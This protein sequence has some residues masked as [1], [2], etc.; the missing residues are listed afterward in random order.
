MAIANQKDT[1]RTYVLFNPQLE[2]TK[3]ETPTTTLFPETCLWS[4]WEPAKN[5]MFDAHPKVYLVQTNRFSP[6]AAHSA[7]SRHFDRWTILETLFYPLFLG[8]C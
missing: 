8:S 5:R 1:V 6:L 2:L 7:S 4:L 3:K